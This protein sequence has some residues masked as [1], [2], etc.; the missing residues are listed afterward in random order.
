MLTRIVDKE[1]GPIWLASAALV[2]RIPDLHRDVGLTTFEEMLPD[3]LVETQF[4]SVAL[5]KWPFVLF[6]APAMLGG[7]F[8]LLRLLR[9]ALRLASRDPGPKLANAAFGPIS[10]ILIL[11]VD[12]NVMK[13]IGLPLLLRYYYERVLIVAAVAAFPWLAM[14]TIDRIVESAR[15]KSSLRDYTL[16]FSMSGLTG[17]VSKGLVMIVAF[18]VALALFG[19]DVET[20]LAGIGIGGIAIALGAQKTLENLIGGVSVLTDRVLNVGDTCRVGTQ[21]GGVESISLRSTKLRTND[22]SLLAVPNGVMAAMNVENLS[23]RT[24]FLFNPVIGVRYETQTQQ[25]L[26]LLDGIRTIL[27]SHPQV[28]PRGFGCDSKTLESQIWRSRVSAEVRTADYSEYLA[29]REGLLVEIMNAVEVVGTGLA[30]PSQRL[31]LA[32]GAGLT[33]AAS[34]HNSTN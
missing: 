3:V 21:S 33:V 23:N 9:L 10:W 15:K 4:F 8:L 19:F 30:L 2:S 6:L 26:S 14:R 31:Y 13:R 29:I 28:A 1:A 7:I 12:W 27:Q 24:R 25:L 20:A 11:S 32:P 16:V 17:Q 18:L 34:E 22:G 5:W